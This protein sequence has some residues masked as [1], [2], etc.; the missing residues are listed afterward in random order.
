VPP[1][2]RDRPAGG[3]LGEDGGIGHVDAYLANL[4]LSDFDPKAPPPKIEAFWAIVAASHAPED[5]DLVDVLD[6]LG[7]PPARYGAT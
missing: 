4:D 3:F 5:S 2:S 7:K 6:R 1:A